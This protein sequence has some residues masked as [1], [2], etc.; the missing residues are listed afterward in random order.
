MRY[1]CVLI[2]YGALTMQSVA[3]ELSSFKAIYKVGIPNITAAEMA[4]VLKREDQKFLYKSALEPM[5]L[6]NIFNIR[7]QSQSKIIKK[8]EHWL[9]LVYEKEASDKGKRQE[10]RF[11]WKNYK[12]KVLYRGEQS[13]LDIKVG[14]VDENTFQLKLREDVVKTLGSDFDQNYTLLSDGRLKKRRFVKRGEEIIEVA[15]KRFNTIRIERYKNTKPDQIYWL[16]P[17]HD[18]LPIK[19]ARMDGNK[20]KTTLTLKSW[21]PDR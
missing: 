5:G 11:D 15:G 7:A 16:S 21:K 9:P 2:L 4:V 6:G 1:V 8:G 3:Q 12:A 17:K 19:I 10:Y 20:I 14:T 18:Y 13:T